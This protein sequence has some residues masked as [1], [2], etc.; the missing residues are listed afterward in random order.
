[1]VLVTTPPQPGVEGPQ[2]VR[3]GLRR[4]RRRQQKR[5][6]E[7]QAGERRGEIGGHLRQPYRRIVPSINPNGSS[8]GTNTSLGLS[9]PKGARS[10]SRWWR[11]GRRIVIS[12]MSC[13]RVQRGF[14]HSCQRVLDRAGFCARQTLRATRHE[15]AHGRQSRTRPSRYVQFAVIDVARMRS[16][17]SGRVVYASRG[18][19]ANAEPLVF[20]TTRSVTPD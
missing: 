20:I 19:P 3:L 10:T 6:P 9:S 2:D 5:V 1:M 14:P 16:S 15:C 11:L 13:A 12:T 7:S 17:V 4:R 18:N 8:V